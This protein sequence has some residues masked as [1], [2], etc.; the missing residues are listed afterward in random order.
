MST[1]GLR[2]K[3]CKTE[4]E[5]IER[6]RAKRLRWYYRNREK[7]KEQRKPYDAE[8]YK[9]NKSKFKEKNTAYYFEN[10][11]QID[12]RNMKYRSDNPDKIKEIDKKWRSTENGKISRRLSNLKRRLKTE[13]TDITRSWVLNLKMS[14]D[15]CPLCK[16]EMVDDGQV[17]PNGKH[18][19]HIIPVNIGGKHIKSNVRY[20]CYKCNISRPKDGSDLLPVPLASIGPILNINFT[21]RS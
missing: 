9:N 15:F 5:R 21:N 13:H 18:L 11:D 20:V 14:A 8:N 1:K 6:A 3:H 7:Q 10:K 19:D 12:N 16:T 2:F 4:A 17:Y